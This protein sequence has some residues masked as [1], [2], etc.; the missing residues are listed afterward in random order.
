M[1]KWT[2]R[3]NFD[4]AICNNLANVRLFARI[5]L[6]ALYAAIVL[7]FIFNWKERFYFPIVQ[8]NIKLTCSIC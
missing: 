5:C 1:I 7:N 3:L 6:L 4:V 8:N 2:L